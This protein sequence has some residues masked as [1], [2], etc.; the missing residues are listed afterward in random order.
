MS[1]AE[2]QHPCDPESLKEET[3]HLEKWREF[4][5]QVRQ[6]PQF[7]D[8]ITRSNFNRFRVRFV[9]ATRFEGL[10]LQGY[11]DTTT[12]GYSAGFQLLLSYSAAEL[13]GK[14]TGHTITDWQVSN[15][16]LAVR[17]RRVLRQPAERMDDLLTSHKLKENLQCFQQAGND[18]VRIAATVLR[19]MVAHGTFTPTGTDALTKNGAQT[20]QCLSDVLLQTCN[21]RFVEWLTERLKNHSTE[22]QPS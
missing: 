11:Q 6:N 5:W 22:R 20:I 17:L 19:V 8:P 7:C 21:E 18:N 15:P 13:L 4:C 9:L 1:S 10:R 14:A 3:M 12:Q 2:R 16:A